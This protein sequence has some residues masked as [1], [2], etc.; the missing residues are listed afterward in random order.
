MR[1]RKISTTSTSKKTWK[2]SERPGS[3]LRRTA[4]IALVAIALGAGVVSAADNSDPKRFV[5]ATA[6]KVLEVLGDK[7]LTFEQKSAK[8]ET[9]L[10]DCCDFATT[11]KLAMARNWRSLSTAQ[12]EEF[13]GLFKNYLIVT[14]R[15]NINSYGGQT[16]EVTGGHD[17]PRGDY[18]V[19]TKIRGGNTDD[20]LVEYRLRR[21]KNGGWYII[22]VV[23]EGISLI[24]NLRSQFQEVMSSG[25]AETLMR[26]M[27]EKAGKT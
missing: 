23:A 5:E 8:L 9:Y 2:N 24:S 16:V 27:R 13:V 19:Q 10:D 12:Q 14:Y 15:D 1:N 3:L 4:G 17:E 20:I 25:G 7:D 6:E 11:A 21:G 18:T 26:K 22:D